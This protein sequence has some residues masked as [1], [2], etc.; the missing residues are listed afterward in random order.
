MLQLSSSYCNSVLLVV[1]LQ[2]STR[3][4]Q[5]LL[6]YSKLL[7]ATQGCGRA[8]LV[9]RGSASWQLAIHSYIQPHA[10]ARLLKM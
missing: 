7:C 4:G 9:N 2:P 1:T 6:V 5:R 10:L 8:A 3:R